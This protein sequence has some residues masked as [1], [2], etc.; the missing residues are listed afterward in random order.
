M[1]RCFIAS[2]FVFFLISGCE[3]DP[4]I[5]NNSVEETLFVWGYSDLTNNHHQVRVRRAILE[6]G[7]LEESAKD[8]ELLIPKDPLEVYLVLYFE[9]ERIDS[10]LMTPKVYSKEDGI[11]SSEQNIIYELDY[12]VPPEHKVW[13]SVK[14]LTTKKIIRSEAVTSYIYPFTYPQRHGWYDQEFGFT[15]EEPFKVE[16]HTIGRSVY[17]LVTE[18]KYVDILTNG[19]SIFQKSIFEGQPIL[20]E[21]MIKSEPYTKHF[22]LTYLFNI[23]N[24]KIPNTPGLKFRMFYRFNF[25]VWSGSRILKDYL[26]YG[27]RFQDNRKFQFSNM[28]GGYGLY[29]ACKTVSTGHIKPRPSFTELLFTDPEVKDLKFSRYVFE[30]TYHD[31]DSTNTINY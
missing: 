31:P 18:I 27:D 3:T 17:K 26:Q 23:F 20:V 29:Y 6:E 19:D 25:K 14:N 24:R 13:V 9:R 5:M 8:P 21:H 11:F 4:E 15:N 2:I 7:S 1:R 22:D 16:F 30:G 12:V 10:F 28:I